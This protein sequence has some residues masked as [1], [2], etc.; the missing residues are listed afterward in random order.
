[1]HGATVAALRCEG[2]LEQVSRRKRVVFLINSLA[3]GGA[4]RVMCSLLAHSAPESEEFEIVLALLDTEPAAYSPPSWVRQ[5]QFDCRSSLARS[6][7][8]VRRLFREERPDATLSFLTRANVANVLASRLRGTPAVISERA[9]T[10]AHFPRGPRGA[11]PRAFVRFV[12]PR[13]DRIIAVSAG[14]ERDLRENF[15]VPA[16]KL[17]VI[18]NPV[19][20]EAIRS[21]ACEAPEV[22]IDEPFVLGAGRLVASKNFGLLIEAFAAAG[23]AGKLVIIGE[24]PERGA[25]LRRIGDLGL[26]DRVLLP[27]FVKNPYPLMRRARIFVLPSNAEGFP[28]GLAEAMALGAPVIST[29]CASGPSELLAE[30]PREEVE[31]LSFAE[32]GVL[33]PTG[34]VAAMADALKALED[35]DL[36]NR[37]GQKAAHRAAAFSPEKAKLGYWEILRGVL[38][39]S[40]V[41]A[42]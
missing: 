18:A 31:G 35:A 25:L 42:V 10:S 17:S 27:G 24:G 3:G 4:E 37:Y 15:A 12:Y 20:L 1:L 6:V 36:R 26:G 39:Q 22:D 11:L 21:R 41:P 29:N 34:D 13:A 5:R 16:R 7:L 33:V 38:R 2:G 30:R 40:P 23:L 28:N 32:H 9:N 14:V 8:A 19:D